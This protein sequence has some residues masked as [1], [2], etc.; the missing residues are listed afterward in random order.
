MCVCVY[1]YMC[2]RERWRERESA[3]EREREKERM[4]SVCEREGDYY[5]IK[6][7]NALMLINLIQ[8]S[9]STEVTQLSD[10]QRLR[11][12]PAQEVPPQLH[13]AKGSQF[14]VTAR[15]IRFVF[16]S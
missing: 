5:G 6:I 11:V 3:R 7:I 8:I 15:T 4:I 2:V 1:R 16:M 10:C 12:R 9:S 14:T 13:L